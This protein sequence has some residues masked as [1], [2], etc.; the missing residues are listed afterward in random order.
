LQNANSRDSQKF[1][2]HADGFYEGK[3]SP[4]V[5]QGLVWIGTSNTQAVRDM[6]AGVL[7]CFRA[8]D[9]QKV[10]ERVSAKLVQPG[11]GYQVWNR[12]WPGTGI[13][14]SP[15][16]E[17]NRL[18]YCT[19]RLEIVCLDIETLVSETGMPRELWRIDLSKLVG[20]MP[21]DVHLGSPASRCSLVGFKD[22]LY[23]T[24]THSRDSEGAF[25]STLPSL[26]WKS[27]RLST[28]RY[29]MIELVEC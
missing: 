13:T 2:W 16:I 28:F 11:S 26:V 7:T 8:S 3:G 9:G 15:L 12:D 10:Y 21:R 25:D 17:G 5:S 18:W 27:K 6:D 4:V 20:V 24:T 14:S 22:W 19:N 23:T 29:Q 1:L